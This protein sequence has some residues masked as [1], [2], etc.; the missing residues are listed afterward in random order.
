LAGVDQPLQHRGLRIALSLL[1]GL[2]C[3][4]LAALWIRSYTKCDIVY[5]LD[6]NSNLTTFGSNNGY[7]YFIHAIA[8]Y[9]GAKPAA[10]GWR[11]GGDNATNVLAILSWEST[12]RMSIVTLPYRYLLPIVAAFMLLPWIRWRYRL[13]TL[14][15]AT[16]L[17][18]VVLGLVAAA[19]R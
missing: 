15:I 3:L 5:R 1:C 9:S 4:L 10:H 16:T 17:I 7:A 12:P 14:L 2:L 18:A 13:R 8:P 6:N 11:I 19:S